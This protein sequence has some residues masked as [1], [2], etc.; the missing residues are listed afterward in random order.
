[1]TGMETCDME[2]VRQMLA[3]LKGDKRAVTALEYGMIAALILVV[4]LTGFTAVGSKLSATLSTISS[5]L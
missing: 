2:H 5:A 4:A 1:M 3:L